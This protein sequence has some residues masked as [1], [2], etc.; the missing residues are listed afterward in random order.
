MYIILALTLTTLSNHGV[1]LLNLQ[2]YQHRLCLIC[3]DLLLTFKV[4]DSM[5]SWTQLPV[6]EREATRLTHYF[7][8]SSGLFPFSTAPVSMK[9]SSLISSCVILR[10]S[11]MSSSST[12]S[13][14]T[15]RH[16]TVACKQF[17]ILTYL[18]CKINFNTGLISLKDPWRM[19]GRM[20]GNLW[21]Q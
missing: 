21:A 17:I 5:T 14:I 16:A 10:N 6:W 13:S 3:H 12:L 19:G 8:L 15:L 9:H 2:C 20:G 7:V 18:H 11:L 1:T 4:T